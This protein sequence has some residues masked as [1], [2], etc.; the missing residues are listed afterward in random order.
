MFARVARLLEI[1]IIL[2]VLLMLAS[3]AATSTTTMHDTASKDIN[4]NDAELTET[5]L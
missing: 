1:P 3:S 4:N 2:K 5:Q